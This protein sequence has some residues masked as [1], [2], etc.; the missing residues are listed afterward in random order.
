MKVYPAIDILGGKAVRL[1]QGRKSDAT[2]YGDPLEMANKWVGKGADWL[3]VVDLDGAF[4]GVPK[5]LAVLREM[6]AAVPNAKIQLGGGIRSMAVIDTLLDAG[7]QRVVLGTAAVQDQEFVKAALTAQP[8][9]VAV[10][11][12]ARDG[13]VQIAGWTEDSHIAAIDLA[14]RLQNLGARL[15]IYTDIARDGVLE[16]PNI[17]AMKEMLDHTELSVIASGGVSS[18][19]DV[20]QLARLDHKRLDG[21]IIGKALYEGRFEIEEAMANA[22]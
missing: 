13:N 15:V 4:E 10:G 9:N 19:A 5:N 16:G 18:I 1:K 3:H 2:V 12:D 17:E 20:R 11:I 21:V 8:H 7:I 6:A 14:R 22:R